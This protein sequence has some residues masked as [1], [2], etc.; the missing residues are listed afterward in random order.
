[1]PVGAALVFLMAGPATNVATIGAIY[2]GFGR[3][4]AAL[5]LGVLIVGSLGFGILFDLG[6][7]SLSVEQHVHQDAHRTWWA[8]ASALLLTAL[9]A[10]LAAQDLHRF[11]RAR[12]GGDSGPHTDIEV[13]GL[14]C[15]ACE[16]KVEKAL[17]ALSG[18]TSASVTRGP[19]RARVTGTASRASIERAIVDA[20]Y[21]I[22]L[23]G[24]PAG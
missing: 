23:T 21:Q 20:G 11:L 14:S 10:R 1:M 18:V 19:D 2:R 8:V 5:Y 7:S 4:Q 22:A 16:R 12:F 3:R 13:E 6:L 17:S 15:G 24:P 9:I